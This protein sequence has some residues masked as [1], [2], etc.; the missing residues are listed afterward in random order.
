MSGFF[1]ERKEIMTPV[2]LLLNRASCKNYTNEPLTTPQ[3]QTIIQ[4]GQAAPSGMNRQPI[5]ILAVTNPDI[6]NELSRLNAQ[7]MNAH[8][9]PFYNAPAVFAVLV[10]PAVPTASYD[11]PLACGQMLLAAQALNLGSCWI[12]RAKEVFETPQGKAILQKAGLPAN[13]EGVGFVIAGHPATIPSIKPKTSK[14][15]I[16]A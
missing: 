5:A 15:G 2:E 16:L 8:T 11:G 14:V 12:H 3:V 9:D 4:A 10:D 7:A 13:Y 1:L 6:R